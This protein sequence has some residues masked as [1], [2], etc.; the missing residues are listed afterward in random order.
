MN[1]EYIKSFYEWKKQLDE[2]FYNPFDDS[3]QEKDKTPKLIGDK[4]GV[5]NKKGESHSVSKIEYRKKRGR[6][7]IVNAKKKIEKD[8]TVEI[9][10]IIIFKQ[11]IDSLN[12]V[13]FELDDNIYGLALGYGSLYKHSDNENLDYA[14][15]KQ[16]KTL[17]FIAKRDIEPEEEL[18]INYGID[19]SYHENDDENFNINDPLYNEKENSESGL[20]QPGKR[21]VTHSG[22]NPRQYTDDPQSSF[23]PAR[24]GRVIKGTGQS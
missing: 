21:D 6:G 4:G 22:S 8:E 24:S 18:T 13:L 19:Y 9:C 12:D 10:P 11:K 15:N 3:N 1:R 5:L 23:N 16:K 17:H 2:E 7:Y 20:V 14:Y